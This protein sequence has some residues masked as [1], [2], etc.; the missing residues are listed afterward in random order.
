M[1]KVCAILGVGPGNGLSLAHRFADA[2]YNVAL[3]ARTLDQVTHMASSIG[4]AARGYS[5]DVTDNGSV[6]RAFDAIAQAQGPTE[7]LIYK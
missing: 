2:G 4:D 5:I 3:C 7:T 1:K 6:R